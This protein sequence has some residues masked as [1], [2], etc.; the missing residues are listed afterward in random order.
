[1]AGF[2]ATNL[3]NGDVEMLEPEDDLSDLFM[4]DCRTPDEAAGGGI[5][6]ATIIPLDALRDRYSELPT[7]T[8]IGIYCAVG[9]RGYIGYRFLKQKGFNV[10]NLNGGFRTWR[11]FHPAAT[12]CLVEA[13]PGQGGTVVDDSEE[14]PHAHAVAT[15]T[16]DACGLQ[17]PGPLLKMRESIETL[18]TGDVL[19]VKATD[20]GFPSD[21]ASWC[22]GA[23]HRLVDVQSQQGPVPRAHCERRGSAQVR[24]GRAT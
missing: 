6:G 18:A 19:A 12:A 7:D 13:G 2:L 23:G 1:M 3:L 5:P 22:K 14:A 17:C 24:A 9:L 11:W 15:A 20:P 16:L 8:P 4:L 21:V 10:R